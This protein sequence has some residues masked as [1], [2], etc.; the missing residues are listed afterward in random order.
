MTES[1]GVAQ[2]GGTSWEERLTTRAV[3]AAGWV[4]GATLRRPARDLV[5]DRVRQLLLA[6]REQ[7]ALL[8]AHVLREALGEGRDLGELPALRGGE[9]RSEV[10]VVA[11]DPMDER[12]VAEPSQDREQKLLLDAEVGLEAAVE[13]RAQF[14]DEPGVDGAGFHAPQERARQHEGV[15]VL[16]RQPPEA[17]VTSHRPGALARHDPR[18]LR[19]MPTIVTDHAVR[20][21]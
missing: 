9:A 8:E 6:A 10:G 18:R 11:L 7:L 15:V 12:G 20:A 19:T 2:L 1:K 14:A 5:E 21:T 17:N 3:T 13:L 4:T 16:R